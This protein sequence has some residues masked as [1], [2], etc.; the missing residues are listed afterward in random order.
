[1]VKLIILLYNGVLKTSKFNKTKFHSKR[2]LKLVSSFLRDLFF[3]T[4]FDSC[5]RAIYNAFRT[6]SNI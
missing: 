3:P 5:K 6:Q 4:F 2:F 1:M